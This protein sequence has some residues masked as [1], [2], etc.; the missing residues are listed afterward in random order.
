MMTTKEVQPDT[1]LPTAITINPTE[2]NKI[3]DKIDEALTG[4][5]VRAES[6]DIPVEIPYIDEWITMYDDLKNMIDENSTM[7]FKAFAEERLFG[8]T[9]TLMDFS[10]EL[11]RAVPSVRP[12][13]CIKR[14]KRRG[15]I[16][17][18]ISPMNDEMFEKMKEIYFKYIPKDF[19]Q[20][21][22]EEKGDDEQ[23]KMRSIFDPD[24]SDDAQDNDNSLSLTSSIQE[25]VRDMEAK[26]DIATKALRSEMIDNTTSIKHDMKKSRNLDYR[27]YQ[28]YHHVYHYYKDRN[29]NRIQHSKYCS[30]CN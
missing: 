4:F 17:L 19:E 9:E 14:A 25:Q 22:D 30:K 12:L 29:R 6:Q 24:K 13:F 5:T 28:L 15:D 10:H 18:Q 21:I 2:W 11:L 16:I 20:I 26:M 1:P 7:T 27:K 23:Q 8:D 3:L